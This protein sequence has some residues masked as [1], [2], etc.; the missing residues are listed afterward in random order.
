MSARLFQRVLKERE[1]DISAVAEEEEESDSPPA[2]SPARNPFDLLGDDED[3]EEQEEDSVESPETIK[4]SQ[5]Q[6]K[7]QSTTNSSN[8]NKSKKKKKKTKTQQ[9]KKPEDLDSILQDLSLTPDTKP[10]TDPD[11]KPNK[12]ASVSV[13]AVD[14]KHLK[15][16][17]ELK[18][19]FGSKVV[20]SFQNQAGTS[21]TG[22]GTRRNNGT[23]RGVHNP[24]KSLL[25]SPMP[26]WPKWD[27][28]LSMELIETKN[29]VHYFRYVHSE[30]YNHAQEIFEAAKSA[31]DVN[32][33]AHILHRFPYHLD[34]LL[35][36]AD[37]FRYSGD[38]QA[39]SDTV[40]KVLFALECA[41]S[42]LF[43]PLLCNSQV[44]FSHDTNK[45][46]FKALF[47]HMR[48]MDRRGC[49]R[50]ALEVCKLLLSLDSDDPTGSIFCIDY[51][52][53]RA[54]EY[55]WLERFSEEYNKGDN[56]LWLF[57]NFAF[58]LPIARFYSEKDESS[59]TDLDVNKDKSSSLELMKQA[60][61]L[62][63]SVLQR[64]VDKAPLK[65][66]VWNEILRNVFFGSAKPGGPTL[67]HLINIYVER[68]YI[69]WR[70]PEIQGL[71]KSAAF[72]VVNLAKK[73]GNEARD[74][75]CV[76]KEAFSSDKNEYSH[77][78]VSDFS[79]VIPT[80]PPEELQPMMMGG[81]GGPEMGQEFIEIPAVEQDMIPGRFRAPRDVAGRNPAIVFLE[82]LLPWNDYGVLDREDGHG[83]DDDFD[84]GGDDGDR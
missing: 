56:S 35:T 38:H 14:P 9:P 69:I 19:I 49:H 12:S 26:N 84:G 52:A 42:P 44:K 77:L 48:Q 25:V 83:D 33:I 67:E 59:S 17:N 55:S 24:R 75:A 10:S 27:G 80:I 51:F 62:H 73:N 37:L 34:S 5:P 66:A 47:S 70:I 39:A 53:L 13:L 18:K 54:Q 4:E 45:P 65:E 7:T 3:N 78:M 16:E 29:G 28:S 1:A 23:R 36:F 32:S 2:P 76:R 30:S 46:L 63:P 40:A 68:S 74:W 22:T 43:T 79:D 72:A 11:A 57:P 64:I 50:S 15:A 20:N 81:G 58:S 82:S 60:L 6:I 21:G 71:L 31:N 8:K 61:M 41:W